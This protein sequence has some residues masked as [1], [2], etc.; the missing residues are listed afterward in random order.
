MSTAEAEDGEV[1]RI[2]SLKGDGS[3]CSRSSSKRSCYRSGRTARGSGSG[4]SYRH[5]ATRHRWSCSC[6]NPE[7]ETHPKGKHRTTGAVAPF[8]GLCLLRSVGR[9]VVVAGLCQ[10]GEIPLD[11][12]PFKGAFGGGSRCPRSSTKR[13]SYRPG[14][15]ARGTG[16][17]SSYRHRA[18]RH[19][20]SCSC[21]NR[22]HR[23]FRC[24]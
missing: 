15:T 14:R 12:P 8:L 22:I 19:R 16:T 10:G 11:N 13:S 18:T 9:L 2:A 17:G 4:C 24:R 5:S 21:N 7:E 3:R 1:R 6:N 23:S 20:R